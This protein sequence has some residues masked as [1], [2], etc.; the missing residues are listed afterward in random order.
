MNHYE[1]LYIVPATYSEEELGPI[2][3]MVK[4]LMVKHNCQIKIENDLGKKKLAYPIKKFRQGYYLAVEFDAE[5]ENIKPLETELHLSNDILREMIIIK[6]PAAAKQAARIERVEKTE[7]PKE[8]VNQK[9][10][11]QAAK[12][13]KQEKVRL[14]DLDKKLDEILEG[15]II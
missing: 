1:M 11:E 12:D 10:V 14:D 13:E 9:T 2:K 6:D 4:G 5:P 8:P 7:T 3:E 15:N